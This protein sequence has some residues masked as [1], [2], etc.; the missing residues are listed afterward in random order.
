MPQKAVWL[1]GRTSCAGV[2]LIGF[3]WCCL[4]GQGRSEQ[5]SFPG[6]PALPERG[7]DNTESLYIAKATDVPGIVCVRVINQLHEQIDWKGPQ[8]QKWEKGTLWGLLGRG[9]RNIETKRLIGG[10]V[11]PVGAGVLMPPG[12]ADIRLPSSGQPVPPGTYRVCLQYRAA[13]W[14]KSQEV[15]SEPFSLP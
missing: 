3:L 1:T 7:P 13:G 9:F 11:F 15:C 4:S 8:L 14:E 2:V 5:L 10:A 12:V 6:C